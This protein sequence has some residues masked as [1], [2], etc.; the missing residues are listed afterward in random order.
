[1][2]MFDRCI[3]TK[4]S[5]TKIDDRDFVE[6]VRIYVDLQA[7]LLKRQKSTLK[8]IFVERQELYNSA[9]L[10]SAVSDLSIKMKKGEAPLDE[11]DFFIETLI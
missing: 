2:D 5:L 3:L 1:M 9:L 11:L 10:A 6:L 8:D 7:S 4:E